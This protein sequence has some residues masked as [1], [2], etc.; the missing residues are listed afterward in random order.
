M[1]CFANAHYPKTMNVAALDKL[2]TDSQPG[3]AK[4]TESCRERE[5]PATVKRQDEV[6]LP[7]L[8]RLVV[9]EIDCFNDFKFVAATASAIVL[10]K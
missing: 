6:L 9:P 1:R 7:E 5:V 4:L 2:I 10:S 8:L 3:V